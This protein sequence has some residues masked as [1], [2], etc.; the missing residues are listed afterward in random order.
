MLLSPR[1]RLNTNKMS[2][3]NE[4]INTNKPRERWELDIRGYAN[5]FC[6]FL[7]CFRGRVDDKT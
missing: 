2:F 7:L 3:Q 1:N 6:V 4:A 5:N